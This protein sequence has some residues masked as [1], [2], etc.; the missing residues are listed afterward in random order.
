VKEG[1]PLTYTI[2]PRSWTA[3]QNTEK[4][5]ETKEIIED[6]NVSD[7]I[8]EALSICESLNKLYETLSRLEYAIK[9][10]IMET[11]LTQEGKGLL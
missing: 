1:K 9:R 7:A 3:A 6:T 5:P 2:Q 11:G 10:K 4:K 8:Q